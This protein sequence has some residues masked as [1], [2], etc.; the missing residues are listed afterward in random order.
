MRTLCAIAAFSLALPL[1][2]AEIPAGTTLTLRLKTKV[3]SRDSKPKDPVEAVVIAPVVVGDAIVIHQGVL[4]SGSVTAAKKSAGPEDRATL[5]FEFTRMHDAGGASVQVQTKL[6]DV[7]NA[8]ESVDE[9][10]VLTGILA[11]QT[12]SARMDQGL[13]RL[14]ERMAGFAKLLGGVKGLVIREADPEIVYE[15]GVEMHVALTKPVRWQGKTEGP[16]VEGFPNDE[17]L[18]K[19]VNAQPF[20]TVAQSPPKPSDM[21]NLMF[22]GTA[23][24]LKAAF[25]AAGWV[26]AATLSGVSKFETF[27]SIAE[28]RGYKEAPMS[29]LLLDGQKPDFD[30]EK[31]LNTFAMRHHLRVW[32]RP[33]TLMGKPVWVSAATHDIGIELSQEQ[34]NFIH[35]IDSYIDR[36]RAKV[37]SDL[38]F[39]GKVKSLA[40]VDRPGVPREFSNATGDKVI[41]DGAMA[42]LMF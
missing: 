12:I 18:Y 22:I 36:E 2:A 14:G 41:T 17:E 39:T 38:V 5:A 9:K 30:F 13:G 3:S 35:K 15:P 25:A 23:E 11:S 27:R 33:A 42:V 31:M 26:E 24:E 40:L 4:L 28:S 10:G 16:K 1:T 8:R 6:V 21:T 34:R 20:R 37:V 7:D 32:K 19:L 29:I